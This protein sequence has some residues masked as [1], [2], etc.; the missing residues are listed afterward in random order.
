[1]PISTEDLKLFQKLHPAYLFF[2]NQELNIVENVGSVEVFME[3]PFHHKSDIRNAARKHPDL[4]TE[5]KTKNPFN[6]DALELAIIDSWQYA[7]DSSFYVMRYNQ[8]HAVFLDTGTTPRVYAVH[9]LNKEFHEILGDETPVYVK[10]VLLPFKNKIIYDGFIFTYPVT[11]DLPIVQ[12]LEA[13]LN[14]WSERRGIITQLPFIGESVS[15]D[16]EDTLRYYLRSQRNREVYMME[17]NELLA[18][19]PDLDRLYYQLAGRLDARSARRYFRDI[20]IRDIWCAVYQGRI[21]TTASKRETIIDTLKTILPKD[22]KIYPF[23][24]HFKG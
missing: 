13:D 8:D 17:I 12:E 19:N 15:N 14:S 20:G 24:F 9:C 16:D 6:F 4:L 3:L 21:L 11:F 23:I 22:R 2:V 1:M 10:T 5:F 7:L 18:K